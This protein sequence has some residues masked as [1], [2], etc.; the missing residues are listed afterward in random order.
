MSYSFD[1]L[2]E[3]VCENE[4]VNKTYE[5]KDKDKINTKIRGATLLQHSIILQNIYNCRF[6]IKNGADV[7]SEFELIKLFTTKNISTLELAVINFN[8]DIVILLIENGSI[9]KPGVDDML[10]GA[11]FP[12]I[13]EEE[14]CTKIFNIVAKS[15]T[16]LDLSKHE[17]PWLVNKMVECHGKEYFTV[18]NM[19]ESLKIIRVNRNILRETNIIWLANFILSVP[20]IEELHMNECG[21]NDH[22]ISTFCRTVGFKSN[23]H[24]FGIGNNI[25]TDKSVETL[26]EWSH[27]CQK[28]VEVYFFN[29]VSTTSEYVLEFY[30]DVTTRRKKAKFM[31][32][33]D[34]TFNENSFFYKERLPL[35][36]F[37]KIF[38][39][40]GYCKRGTLSAEWYEKRREPV[41]KIKNEK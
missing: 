32:L 27:F 15:A 1:E 4:Y 21:V 37:V 3:I 38:H 6:L 35:D 16:E 40:G 39:L 41:K 10:L 25:L 20:T 31:F 30:N 24:T 33:Y 11:V 17:K 2:L 12:Y 19:L 14:S 18:T 23:L 28:I 7:N 5:L 34:R 36:L 22:F 8:A 9:I 29:N 26:F 13:F